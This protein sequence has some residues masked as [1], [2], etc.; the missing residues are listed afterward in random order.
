[1][2]R[3]LIADDHAIVR[4]GIKQLLLEEFPSAIVEEVAD[5]EKL[6][7]KTIQDKWDIVICDLSMPGRSGLDALRQIKQ[8]SPS[9]P[10]LI[11]SVHPEDQY[12]LRVLKAG[13][14]AYLGKDTIHK[15]LIKAIHIARLGK[16]YITPSIAERLADALEN[17]NGQES[18]QMLSDREF[19]VFKLLA[20]G[21]TTS[22]IAA[23][24]S[25]SI[26]TVSTYRA[27]ILEKM[28]MH[29]NA[30]MTRYALEKGLI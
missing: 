18:H 30:E 11:M 25:L 24:L 5:A 12:A 21:K 1:M 7:K 19:D 15:E 6:I 29:S 2:I 22:E 13:A 8:S 14:S 16:K 17:D 28:T 27:R 3:V 23:Q 20:A 4:K 9:L 10:V 26:T